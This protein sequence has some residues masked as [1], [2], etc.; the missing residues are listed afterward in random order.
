MLSKSPPSSG[1]QTARK[2]APFAINSLHFYGPAL[3]SLDIALR[4]LHDHAVRKAESRCS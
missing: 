2:K 1:L 4:A 3:L